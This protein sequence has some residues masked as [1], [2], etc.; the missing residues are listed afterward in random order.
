MS[1]KH[2]INEIDLKI[3]DIEGYSS[4]INEIGIQLKK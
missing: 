4:L 2:N 3:D 1:R